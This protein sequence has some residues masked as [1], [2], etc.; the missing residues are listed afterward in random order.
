MRLGVAVAVTCFVAATCLAQ[1]G[2][3]MS[4]GNLQKKVA[5]GE[6]IHVRISGVYSV[7]PENSTLD[8]PACPVVPYQ[9]TWVEFDLKTKRNDKKLKELLEHSQ[10][11]YLA[12]EGELYGPPL[13]DPKLP[14]TLQ[15][16]FPPHW[17]HLGCCRTKLVVHVIR[18]VKRVPTGYAPTTP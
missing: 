9:G 10:H 18:E 17:G 1:A 2:Q 13:P 12:S 5:Q 16:E 4:L 11:V 7:G 3:E 15:K 8:D 6:H 14:E